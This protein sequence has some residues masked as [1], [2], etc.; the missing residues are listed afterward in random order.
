[1][2][3]SNSFNNTYIKSSSGTTNTEAEK[4]FKESTQLSCIN[5]NLMSRF[6]KT[7]GFL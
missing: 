3:Q 5:Y 4:N 7:G 6:V 1:M 2:E